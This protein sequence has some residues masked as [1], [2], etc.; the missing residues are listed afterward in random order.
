MKKISILL[1]SLFLM[2]PSSYASSDS[3][4]QGMGK[5]AIRGAVNLVT[6]IV[7]VPMQI[8]KGYNKGCKFIKNDAGSKT[9][10]TILGF[11]RGFG[12]AAGRMGWGGLELFGFWT[13]NRPDNAGIGVPL[14]AEYAWEQGTQYSIFQPSLKE[15]LKPIPVKLGHGL[16]D[17]LLGIL[18]LPGQTIQGIEDG[19]VLKGLG[20][21]IWF[22]WSREVYGFGS[23]Y[24]CLV[25]NPVDNPGYPMSGKWAWSSL[26][27]ETDSMSAEM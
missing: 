4:A 19:N 10:G 1:L 18:E 12:H 27:E 21:G 20:K 7:E 3:V 16:T 26:T 11:F 17:G 13:A 5:K 9:V 8:Y 15:G 6:G 25:P 23:I 14:D 2:T 22:W 24:T